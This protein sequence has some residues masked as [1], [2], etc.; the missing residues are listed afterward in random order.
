MRRYF[1]LFRIFF[2]GV[3]LMAGLQSATG[4]QDT[5][6]PFRAVALASGVLDNG[7]HYYIMHNENPEKRAAFYFA[8]HVGSVQEEDSQRGLAHFLEHMAF[9]GTL[10][11]P[12]KE[13]LKFLEKNGIKFGEEINAFTD[14]DKT[15]YS[16]RNV[17]VHNESV[18]D[19][20]L[21]ILHDWSGG[22][23][24]SEEEIDMERGVVRE[25]WRTRYHTRKRVADSVKN[26]GLLRGSRYAERIPIGK[27]EVIDNFEYQELRDYYRKWYRPDLQAVIIVGDIDAGKMEEKVRKRFSGIPLREGL[28]ERLQFDVPVDDAFTYIN[29]TDKELGPPDIE[30]YIKHSVTY[31]PGEEEEIRSS[32]KSGLVHTVLNRRLARMSGRPD[33]PVLSA[34]FDIEEVAGP[35]EVLKMTVK[36]KKDSILPALE[37]ALSELK[38]MAIYGATDEEFDHVRSVSLRSLEPGAGASR[39]QSHVYLAIKLYETF[40]KNQQLPD[41]DWERDFRGAYLQQLHA[42]S[43]TAFLNSYYTEKGNVVAIT[44]WE[45][46]QYPAEKEILKVFES[47]RNSLPEPYREREVHAT[48]EMPPVPGGEI[49]RET[50]ADSAGSIN[51]VLSNGARVLLYKTDGDN[52]GIYFE[53]FSPGGRS[54]L[55]EN[56]LP[57]ALFATVF[58]GASGL[59]NLDNTA[60]RQSEKVIPVKVTIDEYE[61]SLSGH[62]A[63]GNLEK[64]LRGVFL[65]FTAP[66]FD[67]EVFD[68]TR[69]QLEMLRATL[70]G[71]AQSILGDSMQRAINNYS[72]RTVL[73]D[74]KLMDKLSM[75]DVEAV[76]R[77]RIRNAADFEFVFMGNP[78]SLQFREL[79]KKYIG[80]IPG[81]ARMREVPEDHGMKPERGTRNVHLVT[82]MQSPKS[83]V[84]IHLERAIDD[85]PENRL[86][87]EITGK[88]LNKRYMER[89]REDEG[90]TYGVKVTSGLLHVPE[91]HLT[92]DIRFDCNPEKTSRLVA[93]VYE[94][95][96]ELQQK[97]DATSL[98]EIKNQM[99]KEISEKVGHTTARFEEIMHSARTGI[100]VPDAGLPKAIDAVSAQDITEFVTKMMDDPAIVE[101]VLMPEEKR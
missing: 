62:A 12:G 76:Y 46:T 80:S 33:S 10:H 72:S 61:E 85:T 94:E 79:V 18:L 41:P 6:G 58:S 89:I 93:I 100:P 65:A 37:F 7:L 67:P 30:F 70:K 59:A 86:L 14:Y 88:L 21:L 84:S 26:R 13:M 39:G 92:L 25:E 53:A 75:P 99:K 1:S 34:R 17:P 19:S 29:I 98:A 64:L 101:G 83:V 32:I 11:Y 42:D 90:G 43:L 28:P 60:L 31:H 27:M 4:Q 95:L 2:P 38:R 56:L 74:E 23:T 9:N 44:G 78:D 73:F 22:L 45:K 36:P 57:N 97:A 81:D 87:L 3:L 66:R 50:Y 54:A 49:V 91:E 24:L 52:E 40:F 5:P 63:A 68:G 69:Q 71:N 48:L 15:V 55:D 8:Q 82:A 47:V 96:E 20:V 77:D 51:Y 16:I 35:L